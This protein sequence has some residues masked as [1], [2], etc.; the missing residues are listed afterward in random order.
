[1]T[2]ETGKSLG[3][4]RALVLIGAAGVAIGLM[5]QVLILGLL[6]P[7]VAITGVIGLAVARR[8]QSP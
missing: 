4:W 3:V 2:Q 8:R 6:A 1:M 5:G 7:P